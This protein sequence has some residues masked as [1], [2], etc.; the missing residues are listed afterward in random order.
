VDKGGSI[1]HLVQEIIDRV[2][3]HEPALELFKFLVDYYEAPFET[4]DT[5]H[6]HIRRLKASFQKNELNEST[7]AIAEPNSGDNRDEAI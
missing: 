4:V 6:G 3:Y 2:Q 7:K 5:D 1:E